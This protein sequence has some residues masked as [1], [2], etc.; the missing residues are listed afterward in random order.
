MNSWRFLPCLDK[1]HV[2]A[3]FKF[4]RNHSV[5]LHYARQGMLVAACEGCDLFNLGG[6]DVARVNSTDSPALGVDF[7]HDSRRVFS[8]QPKESLQNDDHEIHRG[9]IVVQQQ[10]LVQ[11][12]RRELRAFR[13]E[14]GT[15]LMLCGHA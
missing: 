1:C 5:F 12:R 9:E 15:V 4:L 6:R 2:Q 13:F 10:D 3:D 11:G 14:Q 8:I 7:E